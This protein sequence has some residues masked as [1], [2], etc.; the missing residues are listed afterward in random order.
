M[1]GTSIW[2]GRNKVPVVRGGIR[3][4]ARNKEPVDTRLD[5]CSH[6]LRVRLFVGRL[7][8]AAVVAAAR[9]RRAIAGAFGGTRQELATSTRQLRSSCRMDKP[10]LI[11]E[12][13]STLAVAAAH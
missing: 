12:S 9:H 4:I 5:D 1:G 13:K 8:E 2:T 11:V 10:R 7:I 6:P 3:Q